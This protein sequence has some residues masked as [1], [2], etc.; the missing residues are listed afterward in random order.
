[1]IF[2]GSLVSFSPSDS[3]VQL[4]TRFLSVV[5]RNVLMLLQIIINNNKQIKIIYTDKN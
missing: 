1:M 4:K 5:A 3:P 2:K